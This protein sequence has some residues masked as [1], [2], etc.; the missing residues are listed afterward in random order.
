LQHSFVQ[1]SS[2]AV[3]SF[4]TRVAKDSAQ[5]KL[6]WRTMHWA[7]IVHSAVRTEHLINIVWHHRWQKQTAVDHITAEMT[8]LR[9]SE[10]MNF[11]PEVNC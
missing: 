9:T 8:F 10:D 4:R 11:E 1:N 6:P 2:W 5:K 3:A 7:F